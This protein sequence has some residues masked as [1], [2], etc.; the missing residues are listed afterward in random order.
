MCDL[1]HFSS[2]FQTNLNN[3]GCGIQKLCVNEPASCDP[4]SGSCSFFSARQDGQNFEFSLAGDST[5]YVAAV[6][7]SDP[8]LVS[9]PSSLTDEHNAQ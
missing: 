1:L 5:G 6:L 7:S 3:S 2:P 9:F 4:G 8:T